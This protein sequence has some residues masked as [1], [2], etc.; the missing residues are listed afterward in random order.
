MNSRFLLTSCVLYLLSILSC[1][2]KNKTTS[3]QKTD[4]NRYY[5]GVFK[6][7]ETEFYKTLYPLNITEVVGH[8]AAAQVYEGL[9]KLNQADLSIQPAIASSWKTNNDATEF[10]FT[11]RKHVFFH[12]DACF[13]NGKGRE[14]SIQ[15]VQYCLEKLCTYDASNQGFWSV[16]G[17]I[18]G[19]AEF[20]N[21]TKLKATKPSDS[22]TE[23]SSV[24]GIQILNDS[25]ITIQLE[26]P[27]S[28]F[29]YRL[30]L[31]FAYIYPKEAVAKYGTDMRD[32]AVGT[33]PFY[34][35]A[36]EQDVSVIMRKNERYWAVDSFG[37]KLPYLD[38]VRI[39]FLSEEKTELLEFLKGNLHLKYRLPLE[40][41]EQ[42]LD[43]NDQLKNEY[44]AFQIQT[45]QELSIQYYG[46]LHAGKYFNNQKLRAAFCYAIDREKLCAYTLKNQGEPA[47]YGIVPLGFKSYPYTDVKGFTFNPALARKLLEESGHKD[48]KGLENLVL[49][50][51]A[52]GGRNEAVA[53]AIQKQLAENLNIQITIKQLLWAQHTETTETGKVDFYRLGWVADYPDPENFLN[54]LYGKHVPQKLNDRA[55]INSFRFKNAAYDVLFEKAQ[56]TIDDAARQKLYAQLDQ[57]VVN[58]AVILP[59][60]YPKV[61]RLVHPAVRNFPLNSMEFRDFS[62]VYFVQ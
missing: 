37:N 10:T 44:K 61:H 53:E 18:K 8:R 1:T 43:E 11:L 5:G 22:L 50:I 59:I 39:S 31:P 2:E 4:G 30:A 54:L 17:L 60:Y 27:F 38:G 41:M 19:A 52:G 46:F 3:L 26:K 9:V 47:K 40:M 15:D 21:Y 25:T 58:E 12:D 49:Q 24:S 42:I 6:Y 14:V 62:A 35:K 16:D 51:N 55:Y 56:Q 57:I 33:G 29:L 7:N 45:G 48:G 23:V 28:A 36:V 32:H 13:P 20:Y 34:I